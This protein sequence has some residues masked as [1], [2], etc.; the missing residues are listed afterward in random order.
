[1]PRCS[2]SESLQKLLDVVQGHAPV[3][4]FDHQGRKETQHHRSRGDREEA[5][6]PAGISGLDRP[7]GAARGQSSNLGL[8][9]RAVLSV[10]SAPGDALQ[11]RPSEPPA[12][13]VLHPER[14]RELRA[15]P[16]KRAG[17]RRRCSPKG[18]RGPAGGLLAARV[19]RQEFQTRAPFAR[20][21]K[22]GSTPA[23]SIARKCP[24]RPTPH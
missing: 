18:P 13:S 24:L 11:A 10:S 8:G 1:M 19:P 17:R 6:L 5:A 9:R 15:R 12:R 22:S 4:L 2:L 20:Q 3:L 23:A 7:D 21:I 14:L 16:P